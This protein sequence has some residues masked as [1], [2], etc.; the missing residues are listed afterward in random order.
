MGFL[1]GRAVHQQ[2][3]G[4][5]LLARAGPRLRGTASRRARRAGPAEPIDRGRSGS[6]N[7]GARTGRGGGARPAVVRV[8]ILNSI[9]DAPFSIGIEK[10]YYAEQGITI[11]T[12]PFD[13]AARMIAPLS[14][15]Q[16]ETGQGIIGAG[17][18]NAVARGVEVRGIASASASPPGHGNSS[19][20]LRADLAD[21]VKG[22]ADLKGRKVGLGATG[23]GIE[24]LLNTLL[25]RGGL[26]IADV[27]LVQLNF[28]E[29]VQA[30]GNGALE[31]ATP[32]EPTATLALDRGYGVLWMR[33]D[34]IFPN[35]LTSFIWAGPHFIAN[36]DVAQ[37]FMVGAL[38]AIRLYNDAF[39]KDIPA[40]REEVIP[41]LHQVHAREGPRPVRPDGLPG[42]RAR[43]PD[44]SGEHRVR[45]GLLRRQ[46]ADPRRGGPGQAD[47][48]AL[49]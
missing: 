21:V 45:H 25:G 14:Q 15:G 49:R 41:H 44:Q 29:Q 18:L 31:M 40:A 17:A 30:L 48:H 20:V 6:A 46:W 16:I 34:E 47:R 39:F 23:T 22:P 5:K 11:E 35:H 4:R 27:E 2:S 19:F 12:V 37:R 42:L 7:G 32:S 24:V 10:G 28:A 9:G 1:P 26:S 8:G 38:K 43:R 13:S 3:R 33:A 36:A